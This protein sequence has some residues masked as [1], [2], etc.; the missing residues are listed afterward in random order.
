MAKSNKPVLGVR[1]GP[2]SLAKLRQHATVLEISLGELARRI[3][4]DWLAH[5]PSPVIRSF[6]PAEVEQLA[7]KH[8]EP[9][10]KA[11]LATIA[12]L[13]KKL[14]RAKE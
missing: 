13:R 8:G 6:T 14:S 11:D 1:V 5:R 2:S 3:I 10:S 9:A 4:D 12:K 7:E